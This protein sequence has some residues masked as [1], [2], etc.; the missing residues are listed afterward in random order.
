FG[1]ARV[2]RAGGRWNAEKVRAAEEAEQEEQAG[3]E[4]EETEGVERKDNAE[5]WVVKNFWAA[6]D[7]LGDIMRLREALFLGMSVHRA[8]IRTGSSI[9]DKNDIRLMKGYRVVQLRQGP[10]LVLFTHP[11]VLFRLGLWLADALRDRVEGTNVGRRTKKK[12][13]PIILACLNEKAKTYVVIG[14]NAA[15]DFGDV[16]KNEF[17]LAF[18]DAKEDSGARTRHSSFD[19]SILEVNEA[20]FDRFIAEVYQ[21]KDK[22]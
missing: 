15:L 8:I 20:D 11:G 5:P 16:K 19:T 22:Y 1:G 4:A 14:M 7:A 2:W 12:S 10:D 9:I 13:L 21:S 6:F 17:G 3:E 18:L